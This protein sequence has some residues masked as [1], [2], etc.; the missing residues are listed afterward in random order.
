MEK[1]S[2]LWDAATYDKVTANLEEW[3][4]T[5]IKSRKWS[6]RETVLDAGCGSGRIT[7]VLSMVTNGSIYAVDNDPNMVIKAKNNLHNIENV[8]VIQSDLIALDPAILPLRFNVVFSN[9]VLHWIHDHHKVFRNF[10]DLLN[11]KDG[12]LLIQCGGFG[13]LQNVISVFNTVKDLSIFKRYFSDWKNP[14]NFAKPEVTYSILKELGYRDITTYLFDAPINFKDKESYLTY[15]KTV[16]LGPYLQYL[17]SEQLK[18]GFL[19]EIANHIEN[20]CPQ[21]VWKLD[22]VRLNILATT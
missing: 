10:H 19:K 22:Y 11:E 6:G 3:A 4:T 7:K 8:K 1:K 9:A 2:F 12:E 21:L 5:I 13:N 16:V 17:P 18:N 15:L 14:W 20:N